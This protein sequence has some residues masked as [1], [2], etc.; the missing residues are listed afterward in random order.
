[1]PR[2][3]AISRE[4]FLAELADASWA[5]PLFESLPD[6]VFCIKDRESRYR[7]VNR[8]LVTRCGLKRKEDLLGRTTVDVFPRPLGDR[9]LRTHT[10]RPFA[11]P[12]AFFTTSGRSK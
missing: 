6:V 1:M 3:N 4:R 11:E 9:Y 2:A 7:L 5:A 8:T 12:R 10:P